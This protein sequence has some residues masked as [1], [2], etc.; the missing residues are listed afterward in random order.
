MHQSCEYNLFA[1]D[2]EKLQIV[3]PITQGKD[4][5]NSLHL[6]RTVLYQPPNDN[7]ILYQFDNDYPPCPESTIGVNLP[8]V[9]ECIISAA[10]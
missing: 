4:Q 6:T 7:I 8:P 9:Q 5:H 2:I 3:L 10:S 1:L